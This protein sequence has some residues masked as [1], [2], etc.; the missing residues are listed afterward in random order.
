MGRKLQGPSSL[1]RE[2]LRLHFLQA[3]KEL[4][5]FLNNHCR[6][7][8]QIINEKSAGNLAAERIERL[9]KL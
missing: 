7:K 5:H 9:K 2:E 4:G 8:K 6:L 1:Q 3:N